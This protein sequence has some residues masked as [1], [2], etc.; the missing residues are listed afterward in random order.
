MDLSI[1]DIIT[2]PVE[3]L[4][5]FARTTP[6]SLSSTFYARKP[7]TATSPQLTT[8]L[9]RRSATLVCCLIQAPML[10][11]YYLKP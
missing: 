5:G 8:Y 3:T 2:T 9:I 4:P 11:V 7:A 10:S 1:F 6:H